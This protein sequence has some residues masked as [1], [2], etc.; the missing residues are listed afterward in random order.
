MP[1][2]PPSP[3]KGFAKLNV[4]ATAQH[5]INIQD[6]QKALA[7]LAKHK[8]MVGVPASKVGRKAGTINNAT[9]AYI[10]EFGAPAAHI[11]ARP[12]LGPAIEAM[13]ETIKRRLNQAGKAAISG[14]YG[15]MMKI[16]N[17]LGLQGQNAVRAKLNTGPFAPLAPSTIAARRR[18][19]KRSVKP[20][21]DTGQ[22][23]NSI[24][25]VVT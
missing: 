15:L 16:L 25:Y 1:P 5:P 22:L 20:L 10:H 8:V 19:G 17:A 2:P 14:N 21:I 11:P 12:F 3:G 23:R 7:E 9:L 18:R 4:R 6:I 24:T 13:K